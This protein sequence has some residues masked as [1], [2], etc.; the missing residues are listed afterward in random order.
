LTKSYTVGSG[1][2]RLLLVA[3]AGDNAG[4]FDDI[5]GVT[6]AGASMTL[7]AKET[8]GTARN[9]YLYSLLNPASGANNVVINASHAHYILAGAADYT[10]FT[11]S[12]QPDAF[13]VS[14]G[15]STTETATLTTV[16]DNCWVMTMGTGLNTV[17]NVSNDGVTRCLDNS[18]QTWVF[19]DSNGPVHPAGSYSETVNWPSKGNL[20]INQI[21]ASFAPVGSPPP[22]PAPPP[23]LSTPGTLFKDSVAFFN[24]PG[25]GPLANVSPVQNS[26]NPAQGGVS[27]IKGTVTLSANGT[28]PANSAIGEWMIDGAPLGS[29]YITGPPFTYTWNTDPSLSSNGT[30]DG[31][32]I[33]NIRIVDTTSAAGNAYEADVGTRPITVIV[34]NIGF[35]NGT[36]TVAVAGFGSTV[37]GTPDF[38]TYQGMPSSVSNTAHPTSYLLTSPVPPATADSR[39]NGAPGSGTDPALLR[40]PSIWYGEPGNEY[41]W[42]EYAYTPVFETTQ[43]GGIFQARWNPQVSLGIESAYKFVVRQNAWDGGRLNC[44]QSPWAEYVD[45]PDGSGFYGAEL[46]GRISKYTFDGAVTTIFGYKRDRTRLNID[47]TDSTTTEAQVRRTFVGTTSGVYSPFDLGGCNDLC[48]DPRNPNI[49]YVACAFNA[50]FIARIDLSTNNATVYAGT[51]GVSGYVEANGTTV[52]ATQARFNE[53]Y[54]ICCADGTGHDIIGTLYVADTN[55]NAIRKILPTGGSSAGATAG[56]VSTIIGGTGVVQPPDFTTYFNNYTTYV[57]TTPV[58]PVNRGYAML[59]SCV[60]LTSLQNIVFVET[61][62]DTVRHADLINNSINVVGVYGNE[63]TDG[64]LTAPSSFRFLDVDNKGTCGPLNDII[65]FRATSGAGHDLWRMSLQPGAYGAVWNGDSGFTHQREGLNLVQINNGFGAYSWSIAFSRTHGRMIGG[66]IGSPNALSA[67]IAFSS[68]P[69]PNLNIGLYAGTGQW[70]WLAGTCANVFHF[71]GADGYLL[72]FPWNSRP[73]FWCLMGPVGTASL[74][75]FP[76]KNT[77]DDLVAAFPT[78]GNFNLNP[79]DPANAGTLVD[80]IQRGLGGSVPR[81]EFTGNNARDL[82][83]WI[84]RTATSG[85]YPIPVTPGPTNTDTTPP[86]ITITSVTHSGNTLT[87]TWN[88]DKPTYGVA[89]AG[90]AAQQGYNYGCPYNVFAFEPYSSSTGYKTTGH[91][92]TIT[93]LPAVSPIHYAVQVKDIAGNTSYTVDAIIT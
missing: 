92:A 76:G 71:S 7:V 74:G 55:N 10:G 15:G 73:S 44:Q 69:A 64:K 81:P 86:V 88:T 33:L 32:H 41:R 8:G 9:A 3:I 19:G 49:L 42:A 36:Q 46:N 67:R 45:A 35:N 17:P 27:V 20:G 14:F 89:C 16:A 11:Q 84:R 90:S 52:P 24:P 62:N 48:F 12:G 83:Y 79:G 61:W 5:T 47:W 23:A 53:P 63:S 58:T 39:Y 60:R 80:Y 93:G 34:A 59:P 29:G 57:P 22:P 13:S 43:G 66:S 30:A 75:S 78:D 21:I 37:P 82:C 68:D 56:A 26:S 72:S 50:H 65:V 77:F 31:T 28:L 6:Y 91:T 18:F 4:G 1:S 25:N 51:V 40:D 70:Q 85:A 87:I 2:N 38:I 54:S